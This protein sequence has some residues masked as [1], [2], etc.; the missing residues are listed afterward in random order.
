MTNITEEQRLILVKKVSA[1]EFHN[2]A[3]RAL[4]KELDDYLLELKEQYGDV[5]INLTSGEVTENNN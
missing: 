1:I 4:K 3:I 2:E 5:T